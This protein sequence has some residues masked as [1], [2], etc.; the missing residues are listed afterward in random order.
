MLGVCVVL[1]GCFGPEESGGTGPGSP[2]ASA[3][4]GS[5]GAGGG[6]TGGAGGD[7]GRPLDGGSHRPDAT[8]SFDAGP[9]RDGGAAGQC[10]QPIDVGPCD[11]AIP[12]WAWDGMLG[13]C[14]QFSYGGCQGNANN[15]DSPVA[16]LQAC[17]VGADGSVG[18]A[19]KVGD[20]VFAD[21]TGNI[22]DPHSCNTCTCMEGQL[23]CTEIGCPSECPPNRAPSTGCAACGPVDQCLI[24]EHGCLLVCSDSSQCTGESATQC[25]DGLCRG[26]C[27]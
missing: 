24:V 17:A 13:G 8:M 4:G 25:F 3:T 20:V 18:V 9:A 5:G 6:G 26:V 27:G 1:A 23:A 16:C 7:G 19:C 14:V 15:F 21:G 10:D 11:A 22:A 12:R 2:D